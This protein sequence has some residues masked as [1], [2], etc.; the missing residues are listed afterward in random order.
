MN[1]KINPKT[2]GK[3]RIKETDAL[4]KSRIQPDDVII[5]V[6]GSAFKAA[7]ASRA[8]QN[9]VISANLIAVTVND[10]ILPELI[11]AYLNSTMGQ[12]ELQSRAVGIAQKSINPKSLME[13]CIPI[14]PK[15]KQKQLTEYFLLSKEYDALIERERE[16]RKQ[17]NNHIV[18]I[19]M[20]R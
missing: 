4:G 7:T 9:Y 3:I 18:Q 13:I 15:D 6:K 20:M 11:V 8:V 10:E 5:T 1:G 19:Y 14:P 16:L 12:L 2:V 17:I